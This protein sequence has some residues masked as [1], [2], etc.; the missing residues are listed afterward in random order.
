MATRLYF[1]STTAATLTP[2]YDTTWMQTSGALRR[3]LSNAK[4]ASAFQSHAG[5]I[6][7]DETGG[8]FIL[9]RQYVTPGLVEGQTITGTVEG[10]FRAMQNGAS[11]ID[12]NEYVIIRV[13][14]S[15]GVT[16]RG[17]LYDD[18][19]N[20]GEFAT[21]L[22]NRKFIPTT[23][24]L[25]PVVAEDVD[26]IVIEIGVFISCRN[27]PPCEP[28]VGTVEF[29]D[30]SVSDLP[31][32]NTTTDQFCPWI[33]FSQD[34]VF[35]ATDPIPAST[36]GWKMGGAGTW[37]ST[38]PTATVI[39]AIDPATGLPI[40][41]LTGFVFAGGTTEAGVAEVT[42]TLPQAD[43]IV[44]EGGF[45]FCG[46]EV[47][48]G[49]AT[50]FPA[51]TVIEPAAGFKFGG[52]GVWGHV[53]PEDLPSAVLVGSGGW[54]LE[55]T[56][57]PLAVTPT[58]TVLV[59][60]GGWKLGGLRPDPVEVS[61][62]E[63]LDRVIISSGGFEFCGDPVG[64]LATT[65]TATVIPS[66]GAIFAIAGAGLATTRMPPIAV[67]TGDAL[68]GWVLAGPDAAEVFEAWCLS[69]QAFEPSVFSGFDFN[70]F[71]VKGGQVY[72]AGEDGIYLLGADH[73]AGETIQTGA[74]IGP[75]N[76]GGAGTKRIRGV[77]FG[78]GGP[79]TRVRVRTDEAEGV[80]APDRDTDRV[81]VSRD[82]QASE[83]TVD[84]LNF[85]ELSHLEIFPLKLARR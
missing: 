37:A 64:V 40:V 43:V 54:V 75:V 62:P 50:T 53:K 19:V 26:I 13:F 34:L 22:T 81:T 60:T 20:V 9:L 73:D 8:E 42:T 11:P 55:G 48:G 28:D 68:G 82:L 58:A 76:F 52:A 25:T 70:S 38:T 56:G 23:S 84:I 69:G 66:D 44:A 36:G 33:E 61:Y 12:A 5:T 45:A 77:V 83:F 4:L 41:S 59:P 3:R 30:N 71:A 10:Q 78:D 32:D 17:V 31:E 79:S 51:T 1:P 14:D 85:E 27:T 24:A 18:G 65:P 46:Q 2:A 29:G 16:E 15:T 47:T 67:I 57:S 49:A 35:G 7:S 39:P 63:D 6:S 80:F 72:A 21:V 74:R